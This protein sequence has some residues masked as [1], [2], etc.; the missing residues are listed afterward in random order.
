MTLPDLDSAIFS[1]L[2]SDAGITALVGTKIAES[3]APASWSYPF[4]VFYRA[5]TNPG[6][7]TPRDTLRVLY[8]VEAWART[9]ADVSQLESA[10]FAALHE[11]EMTISGWKNYALNC[12][13]IQSFILSDDKAEY[14]RKVLDIVA[15]M[16]KD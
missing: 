14:R 10:I 5:S 2:N 12:D 6:N 11:K 4:I 8:R 1:T 16:S 15:R 7:S 3:Q 9:R 13:G